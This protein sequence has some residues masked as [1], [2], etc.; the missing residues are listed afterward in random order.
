[1][2]RNHL[3]YNDQVAKRGELIFEQAMFKPLQSGRALFFAAR[4]DGKWPVVDFYVELRG[5][6]ERVRGCLIAQVKATTAKLRQRAKTLPIALSRKSRQALF[7][8]P[9]PTYLFGVHEPSGRVFVLSIN[10]K[11]ETGVYRIPLKYELT[12][13]NLKLLYKEVKD[14][15]LEH[16]RKPEGSAF[17]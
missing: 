11:S 4:L 9:G 10:D 14:F 17:K 1:M 2:K 8:F 15:W 16:G 3:K 6:R 12:L 13:T 7:R 5:I